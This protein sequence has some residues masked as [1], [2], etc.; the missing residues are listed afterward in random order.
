MGKNSSSLIKSLHPY[1]TFSFSDIVTQTSLSHAIFPR[2]PMQISWNIFKVMKFILLCNLNWFQ[3]AVVF[4][5][6]MLIPF[7]TFLFFF[8]KGNCSD[9]LNLTDKFHD[10]ILTVTRGALDFPIIPTKISTALN[11][12]RNCT[13]S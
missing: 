1:L 4:A 9:M 12:L 8:K 11:S 6:F 10:F 5:F 7:W 3:S 2:I 13:T